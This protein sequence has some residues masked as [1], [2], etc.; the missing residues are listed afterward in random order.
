MLAQMTGG[1]CALQL[2]WGASLQQHWQGQVHGFVEENASPAFR[3]AREAVG[4]GDYPILVLT[5]M[6]ELKDALRYHNSARALADWADLARAG[7]P[8]VRIY[9]YETWHRLDDP[10]G[11]ETRVAEDRRADRG[12]TA[13]AVQNWGKHLVRGG[14]D[15]RAPDRIDLG[16]EKR[17]GKRDGFAHF[18][19]AAPLDLRA[20]AGQ[21]GGC[22]VEPARGTLAHPV[23][24]EGFQHRKPR[25]A[26]G[27]H[28]SIHGTAAKARGQHQ[29]AIFD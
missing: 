23:H 14:L 7:R 25:R 12:A 15:Y 11:W 27:R 28:R 4:S 21:P 1:S 22:I 8:D 6:T 10:A 26:E 5:E 19:K 24:R 18:Q 17:P 9:L 2:G 16:G 13:K 3:P 29:G 20:A